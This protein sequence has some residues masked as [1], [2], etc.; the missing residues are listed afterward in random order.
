MKVIKNDSYIGRQIIISTPKGPQSRWLA[1]RESIA[2]PETALT[3]TIKNL[4]QRRV[5]KITNA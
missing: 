4:A 1:P 2:V 3:N 5:L